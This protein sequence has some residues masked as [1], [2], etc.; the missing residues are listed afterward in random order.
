MRMTLKTVLAVLGFALA[1]QVAATQFPLFGNAALDAAA[2]ACRKLPD[3]FVVNAG[4]DR[5][6]GEGNAVQHYDAVPDAAQ[7][8]F[9]DPKHYLRRLE[10]LA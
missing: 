9:W 2:Q 3:I 5:G 8:E 1:T 6:E 7:P 4:I 10:H